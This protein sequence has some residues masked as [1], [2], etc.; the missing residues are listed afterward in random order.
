MKKELDRVADNRDAAEK[1]IVLTLIAEN[2]KLNGVFGDEDGDRLGK[3]S[4][5]DLHKIIKKRIL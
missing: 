1:R 4:T 2:F 3:K 5:A